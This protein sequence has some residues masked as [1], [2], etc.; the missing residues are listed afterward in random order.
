MS[1]E[2]SEKPAK[3]KLGMSCS[4]SDCD[5]D[6]HCFRSTKKMVAEN[7]GGL[8]R[9]C[10]AGLVDWAR[11]HT[12]N[13]ADVSY[14][15]DALKREFIRHE[16]WHM[17]IDEKAINYARRKG[18]LGM[19]EAA[20]R[21]IEKSIG[22]AEPYRDGRQTGWNENPLYYAQHATATCCRR[23]LE[24]WHHIPRGQELTDDEVSYCAELL[25][26]FINDR[27]PFLKD[28]GEKVPP[29]RQQLF[30]K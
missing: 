23:C 12:R 18:R 16:I 25:M 17:E 24:Y 13:L 19:K 1:T 10:G 27:L 28:T 29:I 3:K 7:K 30:G 22:P 14:T 20:I 11:V 21:R 4:D 6:L 5:N 8:C 2:Q 9:Y 26:L 15:F